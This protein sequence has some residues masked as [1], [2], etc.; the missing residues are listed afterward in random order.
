M[1]PGVAGGM[2]N[3]RSRKT[4]TAE[5]GNNTREAGTI[6][7]GKFLKLRLKSSK[8][9]IN[10]KVILTQERAGEEDGNPIPLDVHAC[11]VVYPR[12]R[13]LEFYL[14]NS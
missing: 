5:G 10:I 11:N 14:L 7:P 9:E 2:L 1:D 4:A 3:G 6:I 12:L 13:L 8:R